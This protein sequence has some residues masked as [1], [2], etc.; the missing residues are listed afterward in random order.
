MNQ[1]NLKRGEIVAQWQFIKAN[2]QKGIGK[3][4]KEP[5]DFANVTVSDGL[6]SFEIP[7]FPPLATSINEGL[8]NIKKA[9]DVQF[10]LALESS[11]R[12]LEWVV[13]EVLKVEVKELVK[14]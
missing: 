10:K 11:H 6:E 3:T 13:Q 12:G 9:D 5:Y 7:M 1:L 4:S 8:I 2:R 14:N